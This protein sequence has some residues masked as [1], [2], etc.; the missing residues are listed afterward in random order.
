MEEVRRKGHALVEEKNKDWWKRRRKRLRLECGLGDIDRV[1]GFAKF[2]IFL[3]IAISGNGH[4]LYSHNLLLHM[5][6]H[7]A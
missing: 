4:N 7:I 6:A 3:V 5:V 1:F 2:V